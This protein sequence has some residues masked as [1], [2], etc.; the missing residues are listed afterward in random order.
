MP[1]GTN[2]RNSAAMSDQ[3]EGLDQPLKPAQLPD[4]ETLEGFAERNG[5]TAD[6]VRAWGQKAVIPTLKLG[7]RRMV[8]SVMLRQWLLE[9][10]WTS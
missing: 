2:E 1:K 9:Q 4:V 7:K 8:N 3:L 6:A 10:D 5:L